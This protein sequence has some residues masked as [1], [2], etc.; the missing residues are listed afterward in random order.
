VFKNSREGKN[1]VALS[2]LTAQQSQM[3]RSK[4]RLTSRGFL[5]L[6][7]DLKSRFS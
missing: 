7:F 1:G 2:G 6:G 4:P 5:F 3:T